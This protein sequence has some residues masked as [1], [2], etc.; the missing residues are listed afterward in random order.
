MLKENFG[1]NVKSRRK[2]LGLTLIELQDRCGVSKSAIGYIEKGQERSGTTL[3]VVE[4][5]ARGLDCPAWYL[6]IDPKLF[7]S[8]VIFENRSTIESFLQL[9][10]ES[11]NKVDIYISDLKKSQ[12][13]L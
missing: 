10:T 7:D 1:L 8:K 5:L 13:S 9:N 4:K 11:K 6:L 12:K 3:P 2:A